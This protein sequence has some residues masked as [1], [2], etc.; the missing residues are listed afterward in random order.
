[1]FDLSYSIH[2]KKMFIFKVVNS[3]LLKDLHDR[4]LWDEKIICELMNNMG[5]V[6]VIY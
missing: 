6:Q 3:Y 2:F 1:M 5:S 4:K